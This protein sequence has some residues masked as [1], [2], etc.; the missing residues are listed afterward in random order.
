MFHFF[1]IEWL[2]PPHPPPPASTFSSPAQVHGF[3]S[4]PS[5]PPLGKGDRTEPQYRRKFAE[6][7][8]SLPLHA[9]QPP[10]PLAN[11]PTSTTHTLMTAR[12]QKQPHRRRSKWNQPCTCN[13]HLPTT[14][15]THPHRHRDPTTWHHPQCQRNHCNRLTPPQPTHHHQEP[16]LPTRR[17]PHTPTPA[18]HQPPFPT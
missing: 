16:H 3:L 4:Q 6:T 5:S 14:P 2:D 11:P 1:S 17:C 9:E 12:T 18:H 10:L 7:T 13:R 15:P 8:T